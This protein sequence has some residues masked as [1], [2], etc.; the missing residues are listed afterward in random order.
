MA[1]G[2]LYYD[3]ALPLLP[4]GKELSSSPSFVSLHRIGIQ[5]PDNSGISAI[6]LT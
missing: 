6:A 4:V 2:G 5:F 1:R 3:C